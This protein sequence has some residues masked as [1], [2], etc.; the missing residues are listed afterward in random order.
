MRLFLAVEPDP[1]AR[2]RLDA[3]LSALRRALGDA[4][5]SLRWTPAGNVHIT[6][7][8]L[9]EVDGAGAD[10]LRVALGTSLPQ[11]WFS[12]RTSRP[13]VF[14][15]GGPPKVVWLGVGAGGA[16]LA[17]V[18]DELS[19]RL[20]GAGV[21]IEGRAFSPHLTLARVRDR[22]RSTAGVGALRARIAAFVTD[23][24]A[25]PADHVTLFQSDLS[26]PSPRYAPLATLA[27]Q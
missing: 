26:G 4:A 17:A 10:R 8:F 23:P 11:A 22:D 2:E 7:H 15:H 12:V 9:G 3:M 5:S 27:L 14:P 18:Y 25:W 20:R 1:P 16:E 6:L 21:P 13:G 24:I 19:H